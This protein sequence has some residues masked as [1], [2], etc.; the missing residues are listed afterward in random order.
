MQGSGTNKLI[1]NGLCVRDAMT[2]GLYHRVLLVCKSILDIQTGT[3][4]SS[5]IQL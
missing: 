2:D 3:H 1:N 4:S 5:I